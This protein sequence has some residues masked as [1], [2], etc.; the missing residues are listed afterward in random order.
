MG[1]LAF[2]QASWA[3]ARPLREVPDL[4]PGVAEPSERARRLDIGQC[5]LGTFDD[6]GLIPVGSPVGRFGTVEPVPF[7]GSVTE[8]LV[9]RAATPAQEVRLLDVEALP[10]SP[11]P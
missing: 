11:I 5:Q 6:L 8:G 10:F 4:A 1:G 9:G 7:V 3:L 2:G